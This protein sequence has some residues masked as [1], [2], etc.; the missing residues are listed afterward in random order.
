MI[1]KIKIIFNCNVPNYSHAPLFTAMLCS[2]FDLILYPS[3]TILVEDLPD[4]TDGWTLVTWLYWL[5]PRGK[6]DVTEGG[7]ISLNYSSDGLALHIE[8]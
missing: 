6:L 3:G 1:V 5:G 4:T 8:T 2:D 7:G